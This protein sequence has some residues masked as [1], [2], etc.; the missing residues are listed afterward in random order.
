MRR[1]LRFPFPP[2]RGASGEQTALGQVHPK[3]TPALGES[4]RFSAQLHKSN[5]IH[6]GNICSW[7]WTLGFRVGLGWVYSWFRVG[8]WLRVG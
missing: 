8:G 7:P 3:E 1:S 5:R 2:Q 4:L 6:V